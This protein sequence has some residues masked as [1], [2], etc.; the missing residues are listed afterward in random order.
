MTHLP[1][2]SR[3]PALLQTVQLRDPVR[4][5]ESLRRRHGPVF[6]MKLLGLP[7][8]VVVSTADLAAEIY[9]TD[10]DGS[11]AG[12]LRAGFVPWLGQFSLFT[13]DGEPWWRHRKLLSPTLH[14][15]SIAGY[16]DLIAEIAAEDIRT[17]PLGRPF[18]LQEHMQS[19]TLEI[20]LRLVFGVRD[21][22]QQSRLRALLLALS[23]ASGSP[24][25]FLMPA[26]L[27][28]WAE[29]SPLA[30]RVPFLPTTRTM[31]ASAAVD[32]VLFGEIAR[33]REEGDREATDVLGR[34][35]QARD[36]QGRP[37]N[38]QEIRDELI[39]LLEAGLETTATGLSWAFERLMRSPE[40]LG[41][42]REEMERG[43]DERYLD[44]VVKEVLRLRTVIYGSGR[45][46]DK[47]LRLG[48]YE[49]PAGWVAIPMFS[50][51]HQDSEVYPEP[52]EFRPERFL[53]ESAKTAQKSFLPFGG[54]RRYCVGAQLA[55][56][57][58]KV[59]I[60]EVLR[61][62]EL[63]PATPEPEAQRMWHATLIPGKHAV[64]VARQRPLTQPPS[65]E[66]PTCPVH[67]SSPE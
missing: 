4:Y 63:T 16:P 53:G 56:M 58:M 13:N 20:T 61:R 42:L 37:M 34:L 40:V 48:G 62:V 39:T 66:Q 8:Q 22:N 67:P 60:R 27:R 14:G 54:G 25:L 43:E 2:G 15:R 11:R 44:A 57:E 1:P 30:T 6:R 18:A 21:V 28:A 36:E 3:Q 35:L 26:R 59:I 46:L 51:I 5:L 29:K 49:I 24:A 33:R 45:L 41:R 47:P 38:D 32:K 17:W 9:R 65:A 7:P 64:A 19:I 10:G 52:Q 50:L 12:A 55:T 23:K 31:R